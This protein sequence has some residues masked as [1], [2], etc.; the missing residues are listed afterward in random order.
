MVELC[1]IW[2]RGLRGLILFNFFSFEKNKK[3]RGR[4]SSEPKRETGAEGP[5]V[6]VVGGVATLARFGASLWWLLRVVRFS[7]YGIVAV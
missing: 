4:S 5:S 3:E 7:S 6:G 2:S 1:Q